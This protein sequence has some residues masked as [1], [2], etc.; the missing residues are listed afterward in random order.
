MD[1]L[2]GSPGRC[3]DLF[4]RK[5]PLLGLFAGR[6]IVSNAIVRAVLQI[7][8]P[9][10][11]I[12]HSSSVYPDVFSK[13]PGTD[14]LTLLAVIRRLIRWFQTHLKLACFCTH[15]SD[16]AAKLQSN[17]TSR[18]ISLRQLD[19]FLLLLRCPRL[20]RVADVLRHKL[21]PCCREGRSKHIR[22]TDDTCALPRSL[23]HGSL[24]TTQEPCGSAA[25]VGAGNERLRYG[26]H[27][28]R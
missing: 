27:D 13:E 16:G 12:K 6:C 8:R 4:T 24:R 9:V 14:V 15:T 7:C 20:A 10:C 5:K 3:W 25:M 18:R 22:S 26:P 11:R 19:E 1:L 23:L 2:V 28:P 17:H 21:S